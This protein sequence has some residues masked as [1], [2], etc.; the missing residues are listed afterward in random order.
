MW[1]GNFYQKVSAEQLLPIAEFNFCE[2]ILLS[3]QLNV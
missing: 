1:N 2:L 3:V